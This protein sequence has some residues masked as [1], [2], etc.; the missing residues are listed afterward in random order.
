MM[1][2]LSFVLPFEPRFERLGF[3]YGVVDAA[4]AA[5]ASRRRQF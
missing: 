2:P 4:E 3:E 5:P 1:T